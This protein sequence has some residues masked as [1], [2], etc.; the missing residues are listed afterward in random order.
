MTYFVYLT[1]YFTFNLNYF[2]SLNDITVVKLS[3]TLRR[4]HQC[5]KQRLLWS[6][7]QNWMWIA[8]WPTELTIDFHCQKFWKS[9]ICLLGKNEDSRFRKL[10]HEVFFFFFSFHFSVCGKYLC[11]VCIFVYICMF[12]MCISSHACV[13]VSMW[14]SGVDVINHQLR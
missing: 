12:C 6:D 1:W 5:P 7:L 4:P 10:C 3:Q 8:A 9:L 2:S 11:V 13:F 14:R